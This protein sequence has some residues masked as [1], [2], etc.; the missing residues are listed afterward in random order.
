MYR[1][2]RLTSLAGFCPVVTNGGPE[3]EALLEG[4][5]EE[6]TA[7][8]AR[9]VTLRGLLGAAGAEEAARRAIPDSER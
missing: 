2:T 7:S 4:L 3:I 5:R 6:R 1:L 9:A 8:R